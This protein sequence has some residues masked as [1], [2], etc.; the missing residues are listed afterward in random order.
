MKRLMVVFALLLVSLAAS[1]QYAEGGA[2]RRS[3]ATIR[4]DDQ[5]LTAFE[6]DALLN[7]IGGAD[8]VEAWSKA[9]GGRTA[10]IWLTAGGG[11]LAAAGLVTTLVGGMASVG[12][13]LVGA[14]A[15][16][17]VGSVGGNASE[18]ASQAAS[19]GAEAGVPIMTAGTIIMVAGAAS[20]AAGIPILIVNNNRLNGIVDN[21]NQ[22][23]AAQLSFAATSNGIG[24]TL[25]F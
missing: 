8:L 13:A 4:V 22:A 5:K 18:T 1:A 20:L 6:R 11:T 25:R 15:G 21:C 2:L 14:T 16:A 19:K 17:L 3:G 10:G 23:R 24:L 7:E 12:G 9:R